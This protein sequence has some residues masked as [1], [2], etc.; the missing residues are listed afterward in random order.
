[1]TAPGPVGSA[2]VASAGSVHVDPHGPAIHPTAVLW[3]RRS[4]RSPAIPS[5]AS[6][7]GIDIATLADANAIALA[8]SEEARVLL[9]SM[10]VRLRTLSTTVATTA[11][12]CINSVRGPIMWSETITARANALGNDDV[13]VCMGTTRSFDTVENQLL[14]EA[15]E[16]IAAAGRAL[17]GPTGGRVA[18]KDVERIAAAAEEAARWRREP[19]LAGIKA[20]RLTGRAA[21]KVRGGHRSG[22]MSAVLAVRRRSREPF[23]PGDLVGLSDEWTRALH[24]L[25]LRVMDA[26]EHPR[27]LTL[28]DGGLW[29]GDLSFRHPSAPGRG[30]AGL[31]VRGRPILGSQSDVAAAPWAHLLPTTGIHIS[32]DLGP[33]EI[34]ERLAL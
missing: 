1:V 34:S 18:A 3:H 16:S 15:L 19:R 26:F 7:T 12:R 29:S 33:D 6:L 22:Q 17:R 14:V 28:S 24:A 8:A 13:F 23:R 9:D 25:V 20:R 11:E 27:V 30:P 21:A 4:P 31:S 2:S 10:E 5:A 32:A